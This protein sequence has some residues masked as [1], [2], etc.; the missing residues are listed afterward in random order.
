MRTLMS[1]ARLVAVTGATI[2]GLLP[3][4]ACSDLRE[5]LLAADDPDII[6][7]ESANS[8]QGA[9]GITRRQ[10]SRRGRDQ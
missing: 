10:C 4:A 1:R 2:I 9:E 5:D 8:V 3:F 7:P 6:T